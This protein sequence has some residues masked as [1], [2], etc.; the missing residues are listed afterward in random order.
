MLGAKGAKAGLPRDGL[1]R[2]GQPSAWILKGACGLIVLKLA[3]GGSR[4]RRRKS[5]VYRT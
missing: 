1:E 5:E 2:G 3:G 4:E